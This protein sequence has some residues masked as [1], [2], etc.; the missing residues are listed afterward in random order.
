MSQS[1][2]RFIV[3]EWLWH[4]LNGENGDEK[5]AE[6]F[7]FVEKV[8]HKCDMIVSLKQSPFE[9][10]FFQLCQRTDVVTRRIVRF[11]RM[12]IL[13]N[14]QKYRTYAEADC[15]PLPDESAV[16]T[17]DVYLVRLGLGGYGTV[18]TTDN[19]LLQRLQEMNVPCIHRDTLLKQY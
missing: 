9:Q 8:L 12:Q 14:Q 19:P 6:A 16:K 4:D 11:F 15:P 3:D 1:K 13:Q 17:D 7:A 2:Q 18:V 10:K 5:R